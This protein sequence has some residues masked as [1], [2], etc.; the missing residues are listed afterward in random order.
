[1]RFGGHSYIWY[2]HSQAG[3]WHM[4]FRLKTHQQHA[5]VFS[6]NGT[7]QAVLEVWIT[8]CRASFQ[9]KK[10]LLFQGREPEKEDAVVN[11]SSN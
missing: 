10:H 2:Q 4:H 5:V 6:A 9:C 1:M 7:D 3:S 8:T 11:T